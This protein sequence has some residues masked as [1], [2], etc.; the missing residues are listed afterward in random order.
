MKA[1]GRT[2]QLLA[3]LYGALTP[4]EEAAFQVE[5]EGDPEL[6]RLLETEA[7]LHRRFPV[8]QGAAVPEEALA[9]SR[10]ALRAALRRES[11]RRVA[12]PVATLLERR[13]RWLAWAVPV[14]LFAGI[15]VGR[16][17]WS[18]FPS[19]ESGTGIA[20]SGRVVDLRLREYDPA[21]GTVSLAVD[22][23][24]S[25]EIRGHLEDPEI[26][27]LLTQ[28][29]D[30]D[31][32]P[33]ARLAAVELLRHQGARTE[34]RQALVQALLNDPNPGV[35]LL[36]AEA[37]AGQSADTSVQQAL[38]RALAGDV[39]PGVRV[40]AVEA[41]RKEGDEP[42]RRALERA[43]AVDGNPYIRAEARRLL[44]RPDEGSRQSEL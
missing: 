6:A 37:L 2:E 44:V 14:A 39:N 36:A 21:T 40:A 11:S 3:H 8:G 17:G 9:E 20:A 43:V 1:R 5:V 30:R 33:G 27:Q 42:T 19:M 35:R 16:A 38:V 41:L 4:D 32:L 22:L 7:S 29:L 23:V 18:P 10:L 26:R 12:G 28:A 15:L 34:I 31:L 25:R 24:S 13:W